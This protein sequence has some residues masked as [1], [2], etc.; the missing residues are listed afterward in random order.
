MFRASLGKY[1]IIYETI[2]HSACGLRLIHLL[3]DLL[4]QNF[5]IRDRCVNIVVSRF[6]QNNSSKDAFGCNQNC[7]WIAQWLRRIKDICVNY[8]GGIYRPTS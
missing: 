8:T 7:C 6:I 2:L 5:E 4:C 3:I 1:Q